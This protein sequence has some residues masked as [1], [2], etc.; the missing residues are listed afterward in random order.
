MYVN[1]P[2]SCFFGGS[3]AKSL[4]ITLDRTGLE[5]PVL[6]TESDRKLPISA[7]SRQSGNHT[8]LARNTI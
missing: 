5:D 4:M 2:K 3:L 6:G 8:D 1:F 7:C